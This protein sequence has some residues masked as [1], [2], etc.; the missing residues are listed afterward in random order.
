MSR[1]LQNI[2][3]SGEVTNIQIGGVSVDDEV[4]T[5]GEV[6]AEVDSRHSIVMSASST[7][8]SQLPSTTDTPLQVE[9]GPLQSETDVSLAADGTFTINTSGKYIFDFMFHYGRTGATGTSIML[10]RVLVNGS[11]VNGTF[12]SKIDGADTLIPWKGMIT[13]D[14]TAG[15]TVAFEIMRDSA[16]NDSGGL[17]KIDPT[18]AGWSDAPS[19]NATV[20]KL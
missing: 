8:T 4:M 19:A 7:A 17:Y 2:L 5:K 6:V 14:L 15:N 12:A 3:S 20:I 10:G 16:G 9:F 13:L 18:L 11:Q 1:E